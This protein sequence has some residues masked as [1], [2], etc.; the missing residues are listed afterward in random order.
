[1]KSIFKKNFSQR[2]YREKFTVW[3]QWTIDAIN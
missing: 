1:M 3:R 2:N